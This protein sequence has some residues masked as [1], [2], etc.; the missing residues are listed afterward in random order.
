MERMG[1]WLISALLGCLVL[2]VSGCRTEETPEEEPLAPAS[3]A[4]DNALLD[5][6]FHIDIRDVQVTFDYFPAE[7]RVDARARLEFVVRAGQTLARF[8]FTP[9]LDQPA[10]V[11]EILLDGERL[12]YPGGADGRIVTVSGSS[13]RILELQRPLLG[14]GLHTLEVAYR[15][16]LSGEYPLFS[17]AVNDLEGRGNEELFPTLNSP[18]ELACHRLT[19]RVHGDRPFRCIGSGRVTRQ[20]DGAVQQ[21]LLDSERELASY[22]VMFALL[23][24]DGSVLEERTIDGVPV[25]ILAFQGGASVETAFA[26]LQTWLPQLQSELGPYPAPPGLSVFLVSEGG[27][28]EYYGGT[29]TSLYALR[30]EVLHGYFGCSVVMKTYRD[31]WLDEALTEWYDDTAGGTVYQA[32]PD[33]YVGN[34]VGAYSPVAVGYSLLAYTDGARIMQH[35]CDSLGGRE[36]MRRFLAGVYEG[37]R[38]QPFTTMEFVS[39]LR[40]FSG[41]DYQGRFEDWLY[42]GQ[43]QGAAAPPADPR[44]KRPD[45]T[46]PRAL[47]EREAARRDPQPSG[48]HHG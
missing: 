7:N 40:D 30:H 39:L 28:M 34:W 25:R 31:S 24:E 45:L 11:S 46:P 16:D 26:R 19:L 1:R 9:L 22:T 33:A 13:Q 35:L 4:A 17:T 32:I 38:F 8:H 42:G 10:S 2:S 27:G 18:A 14:Q 48:G 44:R 43:T 21:W 29:I 37:H 12:A 20:D 36:G 41:I 15:L 6:T 3:A 23:P 5:E 47:R